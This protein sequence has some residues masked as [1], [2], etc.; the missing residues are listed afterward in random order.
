MDFGEYFIFCPKIHAFFILFC[1]FC[2]TK[3]TIAKNNNKMKLDLYK[4]FIFTYL[5]LFFH[6]PTRA[7]EM[8]STHITTEM[9]LS[10]NSVRYILQ[11]NKGFI[12]FGTLDGLCRYDGKSFIT[13]HNNRQSGPTLA[14]NRIVSIYEDKNGFLWIKHSGDQY[15]CYDTRKDCFVDFTGCNEYR[16]LYSDRRTMP[17][18]DI[19]LW[20]SKG[21]G[22][23]L[24]S[25]K[26][27]AF[28][29]KIYSKRKGNLPFD[30]INF[31]YGDKQ[32]RI[33]IGG[34]KGIVCLEKGKV[35]QVNCYKKQA[36]DALAHGNEIF[37][38]FK[39]GTIVCHNKTYQVISQLKGKTITS[40]A[41]IKDD[42]FI[43]TQEGGY[44]L[45]LRN[46]KITQPTEWNIK[47]AS[48][49]KDNKGDYL[50]FNHTG[51]VWIANKKTA[52]IFS[53]QAMPNDKVRL[54]DLERYSI[55]HDSRGII[56][57][58]TYGNG[59]FTYDTHQNKLDHIRY[60]VNGNNHIFSNFLLFA[61]E[62]KTGSIW[63][64]SEYAGLSHILV[65]SNGINRM[66][67]EAADLSN[68]QNAIRMISKMPNNE[69]WI[70]S[71]NG[72]LYAYDNQLHHL[73]WKKHF[74]SNIYATTKDLQGNT[75]LGTR[76]QG[77]LINDKAY[78]MENHLLPNNFIFSLLCDTRGRMWVGTLGGGLL[79]ASPKGNI[80]Q[81]KSFLPTTQSEGTKARVMYKDRNGYIWLG[82]SMGIYIFQPDQM[83][84]NP[85]AYLHYYSNNSSLK[86]NEIRAFYQDRQGRMWIGSA[87]NG[88]C[89]CDPSKGYKHL[90]FKYYDT[91]K[92]LVNDMVQSVIGD[93]YGYIWVATTYGMSRLNPKTDY[94]ENF[95]FSTVALGNVY[96]ENS[97]YSDPQGN[98]YFGTQ[99][100]L[101]KINPS[102]FNT[103]APKI[104]TVHFTSLSINGETIRPADQGSPITEAMAYAQKVRLE[105]KQNNFTI[106]FS[107]FDYS[108]VNN[109]KYS[110]KLEGYDKEWSVPS[111]LSF[112]A[113]KNIEPGH[114]TLHVRACDTNGKW[115][116]ESIIKI[117]VLPPFWLTW[118]AYIIYAILIGT[119]LYFAFKIAKDF[120]NL[121]NRIA[122]EKQLTEY[123]LV[124]FTNISHEF[125]TPLTLIQGGLDKIQASGKMPA[126]IAQ[127]LKTINKSTQR[128]M[129]LID[130]LLEFRKLQNNKLKLALEQTD[131][132]SF[133]HEIYLNFKESATSKDIQYQFDASCKEYQMY[134]DKEKVDK[135]V[136]NLLSNAFKYT[137]SHGKVSL[138]VEI[139]GNQLHI[140][141]TDSGIGIP[142]EKQAELFNRFMQSQFSH[143]S[144]GIGL[145]LTHELVNIHH[146]KI[147]F[148]ENPSGGSI[149]NVTL[150]TQK[151]EYQENDFLVPN[152][153]LEEENEQEKE[154]LEKLEKKERLA[155]E[156]ASNSSESAQIATDQL[157][158]PEK[159][160]INKHRLLIIE[161]D[162]DVRDFLKTEIGQYFDVH[163]ES[164]GQAGIN[165]A[166]NNEIDLIVCD[167]MMPGISGF[168]VTRKIK[169]DFATSHIPIILLTALSSTD[170]QIQGIECGADAYITKPFSLKLLL[171][172]CI[173]LIRQRDKLREKLAKE[174]GLAVP[175]SI[176]NSTKDEKFSNQLN[177]VIEAQLTNYDLNIDQLASMMGVG[178]TAFYQKVRGVTGYPPNEY[179]RIIRLKKA[180][181]LVLQ[182]EH[183]ISEI[184]Y[185]VGFNDPL[186]FSKCFKQ[187]FGAS[188]SNYRKQHMQEE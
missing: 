59:L 52:K 71:R 167:V 180:A 3:T 54:I 77:L 100:G 49:K 103:S 173:Q 171:A 73:K 143:N 87:G 185:M 177:R 84:K 7:V 86:N 144:M 50:I 187:H 156:A 101:T 18:G 13:L 20:H 26:D 19:M 148:Q 43:S 17:N 66:F 122:V 88:L 45:N 107:T 51:K 60:N 178:R 158:V 152:H 124:F 146:G 149:F 11:D 125:R 131:V 93:K 137:P 117:T 142:K 67:V 69:V 72:Y 94:I 153:L 48:I 6:T 30:K 129:R 160:P 83:S 85:K 181:E 132:I 75:W 186:Y 151:E 96:E 104:P 133:L 74:E 155:Q 183:N 1:Y 176:C 53:F 9:G 22:C 141:V 33:W 106:H 162:N 15:S 57:I 70:S 65:Q 76:S 12:W 39:D 174:P 172:R 110:Y 98:L 127:P 184:A 150:P 68:E 10:N 5:L 170:K 188:P 182:N 34:N 79:L 37:L 90:S 135:I 157:P 29:S 118:W 115:G 175:K 112:A 44:L 140:T 116:Q 119:A 4:L 102:R 25:Y 108:H 47:N 24:I 95:Q 55:A 23:R 163:T 109:T 105:Y 27:G 78:M 154:E 32:G 92:G 166:R 121:R 16:Q 58:A 89:V 111:D 80:Y 8:H 64:S 41:L 40:I 147:S 136:Y 161:D 159:E 56:W 126:E 123:K 168:E 165:Y 139:E 61:M 120:N 14:S 97:A 99:Y 82:S 113:F 38:F 128:L 42:I 2:T 91:S 31:T 21:N 35:K 145:H 36:Y 130:Q 134:I 169:T 63:I 114:Y 46:K 62:D 138:K 28:H 81:F 164:D 179:I